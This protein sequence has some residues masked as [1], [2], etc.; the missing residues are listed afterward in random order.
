MTIAR[1]NAEFG[2]DGHLSF[3]VGRGGFPVI[4]I[5]N[6][7][8]RA[9]I[10]VYAGQVLS[11]LPVGEAQD[12]LFVSA[13]AHFAAGKAIKG[14]IPVCWP[15]FGADPQ[16][17][18]RGAHGFA[19][20]R[21]WTVVATEALGRG[22]TRVLLGL[23]PSDETRR[24]WP[25]AFALQ[26]EILVGASL[27]VAL[28]TRNTGERTLSITQALHTYF[29]IGDIDRVRV[30]GLEEVGYLD[31]ASD[32]D[33]G[34]GTQSGALK[35][36]TEVDRIYTEVHYP[37]VIEDRAHGR[38]IRIDAEGSHTAVVW[39]PWQRIA[40]QMSDLEAADYLRF[41]CVETANTAD[42]VIAVSPGGEYVLRSR[43][44]VERL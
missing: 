44:S 14:G 31:K 4:R 35:I 27:S 36:Q 11:Y 28:R 19:R 30:L 43:Y 7:S 15:W 6:S 41:L 1:L 18:G 20:N 22:E 24:L 39:N 3:A 29:N 21:L 34:P 13:A 38:R 10:C 12:L 23:L 37:L 16:H 5:A 26:L 42:E 2:L 40:A 8:A 25:Q 9:E 17:Q 32:G 33:A